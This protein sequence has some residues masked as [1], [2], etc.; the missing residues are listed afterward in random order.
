MTCPN[1][2][3]L[4]LDQDVYHNWE[5]RRVEARKESARFGLDLIVVGLLLALGMILWLVLL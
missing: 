4:N 5:I 3:D 1:T 2:D